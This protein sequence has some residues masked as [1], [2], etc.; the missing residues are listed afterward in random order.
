MK[1]KRSMYDDMIL[2]QNDAPVSPKRLTVMITGKGSNLK[3]LID[4]VSFGSLKGRA[5][6]QCVISNK[7][8]AQGLIKAQEAGIPFAIRELPL[9]KTHPR[10]QES[11]HIYDTELAKLVLGAGQNTPQ[12][13]LV[14]CAGFMHILSPYFLDPLHEAHVDIINLHP[15]LPGEFTGKNAV[16][17]AMS[18]FKSGDTSRTGVMIHWLT[19]EVDK[20]EPILVRE[21]PILPADDLMTLEDRMQEVE[22]KAIVDAVLSV[23]SA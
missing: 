22:H 17:R 3:A 1:F 15:A 2:C 11:R 16:K 14:V 23:I 10:Y 4:A 20:G 7:A 18:S 21:V 5:T 19:V 13:E 12:P 6:I 8:T 9:P